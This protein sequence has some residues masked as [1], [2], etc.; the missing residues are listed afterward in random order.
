MRIASINNSFHF[1]PFLQSP[2][3]PHDFCRCLESVGIVKMLRSLRFFSASKTKAPVISKFPGASGSAFTN[4]LN[5]LNA[6]GNKPKVIDTYRV[7]DPTGVLLSPIHPSLSN[8]SMI[9]MYK[10]MLT[11]NAMDVVLYEAQRQGRI[12]FYMVTRWIY[13]PRRLI[14]EK[15]Q[16]IWDLHKRSL[17]MM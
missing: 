10:N 12:S 4:T 8:E 17:S 2:K 14:T 16:P 6:P 3:L 5:F 9:K 1:V 13:L 7:L 15:K 11:L